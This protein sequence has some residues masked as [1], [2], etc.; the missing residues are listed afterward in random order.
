LIWQD[1]VYAVR[2]MRAK[3]AFV[4]TAIL[5]L[6]LAIGG[7]TAMFT[8][9][10]AV[11]LEP[12]PYPDSSRLV[13]ITG[14]ATPTR[15]EEM[16]TAAQSFSG[17]GAFTIEETP[18]ITG[19]G[20][21]EV[22]KAVRVSA[23]FLRILE[24][25]PLL[26]RAFRAEEDS[27]GG[28]PVAMISFDL[29]QRRFAA[30]RE[31]LGK[32][33]TLGG[34]SQT[35][36][37]VLPPHFAFPYQDLDVWLAAPAGWSLMPS[38]SR[39]LSP[40]LSIFGRLKPGVSLEQATAEAKVIHRRYATAHP[41][42]LDAKPKRPETVMPMKD[43]LVASV[44]SML[45]LLLGA[46]GFVLLASCANVASLLLAR[47]ASRS[48]EIAVRSAVGAGR[49]RLVGQLLCES[50]L[51][52]LPAGILGVLL[53]G[54]SLHVIPRITAFQLPRTREIHLD[55][56]VLGFAAA[57]SIAT[58]LLFG[59]APALHA[60]RLD[61]AHAL[62]ASG[63]AVY[64]GVPKGSLAGLNL[65]GLLLI[66]Q[67]A[68]SILLLVGAALLIQ[69]VSRL[70]GVTLGFNPAH[71]LTAKISR[72]ATN[73]KTAL[74]FQELVQGV[75]SLPGVRSATA[76]MFLPMV[77]FVGTPVQDAAKPLLKLN[78]RPIVT[79]SVVAPGYFRTLQIPFRR[80]R[81]FTA[82]DKD[83]S[84]RVAIIDEAL[85]RR[86]WP[87][88]PRGQDPVGQY[89]WVGGANPKPAQIVGIVADIRQNLENSAWPET[90]YVAF[91]Q[92]PQSFAML[93]VRTEGNPLSFTNAVRKQVELLDK[94]QPLSDVKTMDGLV[95]AQVGQ[96]RLLAILL[97]SFAAMALLLALM[98]IYGLFAYWVAQR[99]Q[100]MGIRRALGAQQSD[101]LRLV[102]GQSLRLTLLGTAAG[103]AGAFGLMRVMQSLL[104]HISTTDPATFVAVVLLFLCVAL[105]ASYFPARR[106]ARIDPMAALR[107]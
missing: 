68:L 41:A 107:M 48:R 40:F 86:L 92:N 31:I 19:G 22:L 103:I 80:G 94:N 98:G 82:R 84:Q 25:Q 69:T 55:W 43:G 93:A 27:P 4:V 101:I 89:L 36:I 10:H 70:R 2:T 57:L 83:G 46:V 62:R 14:G 90:V 60:G 18:T 58:G 38:K 6:A 23:N 81:D 78:E 73:G 21:P 15:F 61:L 51:L 96:P 54:W 12:L 30:D 42:M 75:E 53:A 11:L 67:V 100:E 39:A 7:N 99:T 102:I 34:I 88:Y 5:T 65:R 79:I 64:Q 13:S 9:I 74:F 106:A 3:P 85:A 52:S 29:W 66:A 91:A 47:A 72:N 33:A 16:K 8:I 95:D 28:P 1:S 59:L 97:G 63:E 104:F 77:S 26:G 76:S 49:I 35:I 32:T 20:E 50:L 44:R 17:I 45:W 24:A 87:A 37:G 56:T 71:V 105:A